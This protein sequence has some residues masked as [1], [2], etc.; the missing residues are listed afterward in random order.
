MVAAEWGIGKD[1]EE[2]GRS[3]VRYHLRIF[4]GGQRETTK[5]IKS[6]WLIFWP[7]I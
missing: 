6:W 2:K 5:N 4:L 1:R 7:R 3:I